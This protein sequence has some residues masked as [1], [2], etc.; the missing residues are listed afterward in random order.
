MIKNKH[1]KNSTISPP[2][3]TKKKFNSTTNQKS[4]P[5]IPTSNHISNHTSN[6]T[7]TPPSP[8][9][10][11]DHQRIQLSS[12][13]TKHTTKKN[14]PHM[15]VPQYI[16][17]ASRPVV[18]FKDGYQISL[19]DPSLLTVQ[20]GV[21]QP[22]NAVHEVKIIPTHHLTYKLEDLDRM[23]S[24]YSTELE[25][26]KKLQNNFGMTTASKLHV[27][28]N[29]SFS[30]TEAN[31]ERQKWIDKLNQTFQY[32]LNYVQNQAEQQIQTFSGSTHPTIESTITDGSLQTE[33]ISNP[34]SPLLFLPEETKKFDQQSLVTLLTSDDLTVNEW[35]RKLKEIQQGI[36]HLQTKEQEYSTRLKRDLQQQTEST[37][38]GHLSQHLDHLLTQ[39]M[40]L[41]RQD[42]TTVH[43][44]QQEQA[45]ILNKM[46]SS[47]IVFYSWIL[48]QWQ[49]C[50]HQI[51]QSYQ[52]IHQQVQTMF[53]NNLVL[54]D[55]ERLLGRYEKFLHQH[56]GQLPLEFTLSS[57]PRKEWKQCL[58]K[59]QPEECLR[60]MKNELKS[61]EDIPL[62]KPEIE[63]W[64]QELNH[65]NSEQL[66]QMMEQHGRMKKKMEFAIDHETT[67]H[68]QEK[69]QELNHRI[70]RLGTGLHQEAHKSFTTFE[71]RYQEKHQEIVRQNE[72]LLKE[73]A[74]IE[75]RC[76]LMNKPWAEWM[77]QR[78]LWIKEWALYSYWEVAILGL[79]QIFNIAH[80]FKTYIAQRI[81]K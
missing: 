26:I 77:E 67:K 68:C 33:S 61:L 22:L 48:D 10:N 40:N 1:Q 32:F 54:R 52:Q 35:K 6:H 14:K 63:V 15:S 12:H 3:L 69:W 80:D 23:M 39:K 24:G 60:L 74:S 8:P 81:N 53:K 58:I 4:P 37:V 56:E 41:L 19:E 45:Q 20:V 7:S 57:D 30:M 44:F 42:V 46:S 11:R 64:K 51:N 50:L 17:A 72:Q 79:L 71:R 18:E 9:L 73:I 16:S 70:Y 31:L 66:R 2:P 78:K 47:Y 13:A 75:Y 36:Q 21:D 59:Q 34:S 38:A 76:S 49:R 65:Y 29:M 43:K 62:L 5:L 55:M 28:E 25:E 27:H